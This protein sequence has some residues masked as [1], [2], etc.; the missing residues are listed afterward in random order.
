MHDLMTSRV[1]HRVRKPGPMP[2]STRGFADEGFNG[3][4]E[5]AHHGEHAVHFHPPAVSGPPDGRRADA[6]LATD[7]IPRQTSSDPLPVHRGK[8]RG[9]IEAAHPQ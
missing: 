9:G 6:D 7:L 8:E 1:R 5:P 2:S 4:A 3:N